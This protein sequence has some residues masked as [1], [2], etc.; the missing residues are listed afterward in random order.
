[1]FFLLEIKLENL[2][3]F[4]SH[5]Q[6]D[7]SVYDKAHE[8]SLLREVLDGA[9]IKRIILKKISQ[10]VSSNLKILNKNYM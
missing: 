7:I 3:F 4:L 9:F 10:I 5:L 6:P 1:M 8:L 2:E